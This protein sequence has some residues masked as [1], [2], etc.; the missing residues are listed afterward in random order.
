[1]S[2]P[3]RPGPHLGRRAQPAAGLLVT[4]ALLAACAG[5]P[6][7]APPRLPPGAPLTA[8][9]RFHAAPADAPR[10]TEADLRWWRRFDDPALADWVERALAA[11][12]DLQ[13][14]GQRAAEARALLR[15]AMAARGPSLGAEARIDADTRPAG[16]TR[17]VSPSLALRFD[18]DADLWGGLA[19]QARAASARVLAGE[20]RMQA[21]RLSTAA[22]TARAYLGWRESLLA[23]RLLVEAIA[24]QREIARL[25]DLRVDAG[26]S[27]RLDALRARGEL[28]ATE[29]AA[30]E[31]AEASR[32][33]AR[34]LQQLAGERP[35][36][37][38]ATA[39]SVQGAVQ[40]P[41]HVATHVA[42]HVSTHVPVQAQGPVPAPLPRLQ[43]DT[44]LTLPVDLLRL[45]PD[46]RAAEQDLLATQAERDV[47]DAASRPSLRLP[48]VLT[49]GSTGGGAVLGTLAASVAAVAAAPLVDGGLREAERDAA[50]TRVRAAELV[51]QSTLLQA[52]SDVEAALTAADTNRRRQAAQGR[53]LAEADEAVRHARTLYTAG[54]AGF[55]DVLDAQRSALQRRQALLHMQGDAA[56]ASVSLFEALGLIDEP[57]RDHS[58]QPHGS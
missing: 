3:S 15:A 57:P 48:G 6:T 30:A 54:L 20:H 51:W 43:G 10:P 35:G 25:A 34:A 16:D 55:G 7:V 37:P 22:L 27:P 12:P 53:A 24:L 17:R 52:L 39:A 8:H 11:N 28:A 49:L 47:A 4:V 19:S 50:Q 58:A 5:P 38:L 36:A 9:D 23:E 41:T 46:L 21:A 44:P 31:A 14:A 26:L 18:W 32:A 13:G 2:P 1:M 42:T 56:R 40:V 45:R 29:A 33:A